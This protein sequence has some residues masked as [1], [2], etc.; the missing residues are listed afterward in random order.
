MVN[1]DYL[2]NHAVK[3]QLSSS[4]SSSSSPVPLYIRDGQVKYPSCTRISPRHFHPGSVVHWWAWTDTW[5]YRRLPPHSSS[6]EFDSLD[7]EECK[8][9]FVSLVTNTWD[10]F[11]DKINRG[12]WKYIACMVKLGT[13]KQET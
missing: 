3:L 10:E 13:G 4:P 2:R 5:R 6:L 11:F 7:D 9:T 12:G 1:C 8:R